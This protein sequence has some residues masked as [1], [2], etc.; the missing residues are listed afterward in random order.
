MLKTGWSQVLYE[1]EFFVLFET[2]HL[3]IV[4]EII[5][6]QQWDP[7]IERWLE[8]SLNW[9]DIVCLY[10]IYVYLFMYLCNLVIIV[11][12]F[13]SIYNDNARKPN[14]AKFHL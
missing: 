12:L 11:Y 8:D 7:F 14:D 1:Q 6:Y 4:T 9:Y 5:Q 3:I 13:R 10:I 2:E